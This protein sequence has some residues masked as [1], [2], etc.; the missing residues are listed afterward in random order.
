[1]FRPRPVYLHGLSAI[2]KVHMKMY[3]LSRT[4]YDCW[5]LHF[6]IQEGYFS[7]V[8]SEKRN[9][10]K[11]YH[12]SWPNDKDHKTTNLQELCLP[13]CRHTHSETI[14]FYIRRHHSQCQWLLVNHMYNNRECL[15]HHLIPDFRLKIHH[16]QKSH[17]SPNRSKTRLYRMPPFCL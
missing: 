6:H 17:W 13:I 5:K 1:M 11:P 9:A 4:S 15:R 8:W 2:K 10:S 16:P 3:F 14:Q 12:Y 7:D